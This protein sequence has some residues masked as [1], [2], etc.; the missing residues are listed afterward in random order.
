[1]RKWLLALI[2]LSLSAVGYCSLPLSSVLLLTVTVTDQTGRKIEQG[3]SAAFLG[4]DGRTIATITSETPSS[5]D[6]NLHW[7]VHS[8]HATS[9]HRP[10]DALGAVAVEVTAEGCD[11][12]RLPVLLERSYEPLSFAPHGGGPAY[13]IYRY[14]RDVVLNCG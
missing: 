6:N 2:L 13:F 5:W 1:M 11:T 4:A 9:T 8:H 12:A 10:E 14:D 3:A 7:W